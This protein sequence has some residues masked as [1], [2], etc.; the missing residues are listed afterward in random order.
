MARLGP[1]R[2]PGELALLATLNTI[3]LMKTNKKISPGTFPHCD[4]G[5]NHE[6]TKGTARQHGWPERCIMEG[7]MLWNGILL[8]NNCFNNISFKGV[9][10]YLSIKHTLHTSSYEI[11]CRLPN[12][13]ILEILETWIIFMPTNEMW[14]QWLQWLL[15]CVDQPKSVQLFPPARVK[16][17][18]W[19]CAVCLVL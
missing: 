13:C 7:L 14:L 8:P 4:N 6:Q 11:I 5:Q 15:W 19:G 17:V 12:T 1:R 2:G 9:D 10:Q 3:E 16:T 18:D